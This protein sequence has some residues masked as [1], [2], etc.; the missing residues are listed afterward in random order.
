MSRNLARI[1]PDQ[2]PALP[3]ALPPEPALSPRLAPTVAGMVSRVASAPAKPFSEWSEP[4]R[5]RAVV[6]APV[7]L[8]RISDAAK[9]E[10]RAAARRFEALLR[11]ATALEILAWLTPISIAVRNPPPAEDVQGVAAALSILDL[12]AAAFTLDAQ[13]E[14]MRAWRFFPS[15]A[16]VAALIEPAGRRWRARRAACLD[17][18]NGPRREASVAPAAWKRPTMEECAHVSAQV[19]ALKQSV[20]E[21]GTFERRSAS[22]TQ[23]KPLT[24]QQLI[25]GYEARAKEYPNLASGLLFRAA[26]LRRQHGLPERQEGPSA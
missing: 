15:A 20:A 2:L 14:G 13:R 26:V 23:A 18:A 6:L 1:Q 8:S 10:A 16:D 19:A 5:E 3:A 12:P 22:G 4:D 9:E 24:P 25:A 7:D 17:I 11:P 21:R